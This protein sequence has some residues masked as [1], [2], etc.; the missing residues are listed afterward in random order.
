MSQKEFSVTVIGVIH[1]CFPEKFGIPRQPGMVRAATARMELFPPFNREEMVRG[2]EQF[3]HVWIHFLFHQTVVE[4]WKPTVRPPWLG[5]QKRVGV[6][7]SRSPHRP[8]HLGLSAVRLEAVIHVDGK[9]YLELSGIDILD[10]TP[11]IDIKPY[12]PYSDC[13]ASASGGYAHGN[14]SDLPVVFSAEPS[15]F[16]RR[17]QEKTGRN[18][19]ALIEEMIRHDPRPASQKENKS[20]FGMLLWDVNIRWSVEDSLFQVEDCRQVADESAYR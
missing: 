14:Q 13:I 12:I 7:A 1:S 20:R 15:A 10:Q 19:R 17:Y 11:V 18:I 4:G 5:G 2:L 3:S 9:T 16:C 6:F 8:N